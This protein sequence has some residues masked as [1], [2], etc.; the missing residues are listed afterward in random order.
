M[1][2]FYS[3]ETTRAADRLAN[4]KTGI[5]PALLMENAGRGAAEVLVGKF[6]GRSWTIACGPGNN[7]GDGF[8]LARHFLIAGLDVTV[9]LSQARDR[10]R[11]DPAA[12]LKMLDSTGCRILETPLLDDESLS[13]LL[14]DSG[15]IVDALLG[16]GSTG[17]PR[18]EARRLLSLIPENGPT[19]VSLDIPSG[20]DPSSGEVRGVA[21][22]A[23]VTLTFL[24]PKIGLRVMP[25]AAFA[26]EI[27]VVPIGIPATE[28]LPSPEVEG[29]GLSDAQ[30]D[31][32]KT[33]FDDHKG[34]KGTVIILGG[35]G[36]YRGAPILAARAALR[37]GAGLVVLLVPECIAT[38]AS[39]S[40]PEAVVISASLE[41]DRVLE[42]EPV[43]DAL[44]EWSGRSD[45]LVAGPGMGRS[46]STA[47]LV[48]W[49]SR[50]WHKPVLFDADALRFLPAKLENP[51][52]LITPHEG[53]AGHLLGESPAFI[54][55]SRLANLQELSRRFG[56]VLLKGPFSLCCDGKRTG[57]V[58]ES[59]PALAVPG[60]GDVLSGIAGTLLARGLPPWR[61]GLAA[62]WIHARAARFIARKIESA[63]G[64]LSHEIADGIQAVS[65]ELSPTK[66]G[67]FEFVSHLRPGNAP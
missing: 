15:G 35:S 53:E 21:F 26:G 33:R 62:A 63:S 54:S 47:F 25:G 37:A 20:V 31:W 43:L 34:K 16:T 57:V 28:I 55:A 64:I 67:M 27:E 46:E 24:A 3:A 8:V 58:L 50:S 60:S 45:A 10:F 52:S 41:N 42:K 40:L 61:A 29:Y 32:P 9:L 66:G 19:L 14:R 17:E 18:G 5:T 59:T 7:G 13:R 30:G 36:R 44:E 65:S 49:I 12:F 51:I 6:G 23:Q 11:N 56:T 39:V 1:I 2:P 48:D 4:E 22:R 38:A